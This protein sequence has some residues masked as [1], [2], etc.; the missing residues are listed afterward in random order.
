ML[1][2]EH[3]FGTLASEKQNEVH[4]LLKYLFMFYHFVNS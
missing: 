2:L 3:C 1:L 4:S